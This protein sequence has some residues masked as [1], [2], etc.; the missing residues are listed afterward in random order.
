MLDLR[1]GVMDEMNALTVQTSPG[2]RVII[3]CLKVDCFAQCLKF[4]KKCLILNFLQKGKEKLYQNIF[5]R[6]FVKVCLHSCYVQQNSLQF[7]DFFFFTE[8]NIDGFAK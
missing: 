3:R 8:K 5:F 4:T 6:K 1:R 2:V 7:H